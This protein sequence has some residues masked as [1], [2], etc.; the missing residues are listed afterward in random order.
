[1]VELTSTD[2]FHA[3]TKY[4]YVAVRFTAS[5][6]SYEKRDNS[7]I[8]YT[9]RIAATRGVTFFIQERYSTMR[10]FVENIT[11]KLTSEQVKSLPDFPPK[12]GMMQRLFTD[13]FD[14][15]FLEERKETL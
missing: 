9:I 12:G 15:K 3:A 7:Y 10:T 8:R 13:K 11:S 14:E 4:P 6:V 1:M 5:V 2:S